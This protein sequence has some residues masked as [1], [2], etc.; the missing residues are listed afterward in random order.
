[1]L[2][3]YVGESSYHLSLLEVSRHLLWCMAA[4][5]LSIKACS[6]PSLGSLYVFLVYHFV[7]SY[8]KL[9]FF[10]SRSGVLV[11]TLHD[12]CCSKTFT[13]GIILAQ[14]FGICVRYSLPA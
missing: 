9:F 11:L 10:N 12:S 7:D 5:S 6:S 1:M 4:L 8:S 14:Y 3:V 2:V 13:Y